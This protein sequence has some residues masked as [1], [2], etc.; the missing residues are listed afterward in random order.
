MVKKKDN[1]TILWGVGLS[2]AAVTIFGFRRGVISVDKATGSFG[3]D[4]DIV[5]AL[6]T[7][8]SLYGKKFAQDIERAL[9]IETAN[10]SSG[11]WKQ[12][13]TAGMEATSNTFPYGWGSLE[14]F[15]QDF[16]ELELTSWDFITYTMN[17]NG[18]GIPKKFIRFPNPYAFILFFAWFIENKRSGRVASWYS[19][20][21][22]SAQRYE[23]SMMNI[24][25]S[26]VNS[27]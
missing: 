5:D 2:L 7:V 24:T 20:N 4:G 1:N 23:N 10:F 27:L 8:K 22:E 12:G 13:N 9:R 21:D 17:E 26:I 19:L 3:V 25:P 16:P 6:G 15:I 14:D 18:T 11:Q